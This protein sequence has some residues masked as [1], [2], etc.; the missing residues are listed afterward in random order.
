MQSPD[1]RRDAPLGPEQVN[2]YYYYNAASR[3]IHR[4]AQAPVLALPDVQE[5]S[6]PQWIALVN[7]YVAEP[8]TTIEGQKV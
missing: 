6:C 4:S 3:G 7:V 1:C 8:H 2:V 5:L